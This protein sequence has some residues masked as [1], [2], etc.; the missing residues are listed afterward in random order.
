MKNVLGR[1]I[2]DELLTDGREVFQGQYYRDG[3]VYTKSA[4]TVRANVK[5]SGDKVVENIREA[6][7]KSGLKDGMTISFHHHFRDG[8][9]VVNMVMK[10]IHQLG[11]KDL[12]VCASSLGKAHNYLVPCIEDGTVTGISTSGIRDE[13]GET[14]SAGKLKNPA[15][16]RTHGGRARAIED[17]TVKIDVAFLGAPTSDPYGNASGKGGKSDCGVLSYVDGDAKYADKVV[18]ITDTLVATPNFPASILGVDVDYVVVV[19]SIG[20]PSKIVSGALR[21]TKDTRELMIAENAAK[22]MFHSG[23]FNDGFTFQTGAGGPSLATTVF[24]KKY[25]D[26]KAI[27]CQWAMGGITEPIVNLFKE[28]YIKKIINDQAFDLPAV[29]SVHTDPNHF[30]ISAS[31]YANPFNKGAFVNQLDFVILGAL[32]VD[33]DFNVNVV[34]GTTGILQGAPGGHT[35]TSAGSKVSI[36]VAPLI[37]TRLATVRTKV[38]SVTTPGESIDIVVTDYGVAVNPKRTDLIEAFKNTDI[39]LT[40][41]EELRDLAYQYAGEPEEIEFEDKVVAMIEYRDGTIIDVVKK[42]KNL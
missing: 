31:Q 30:E 2:P 3:Y 1:E 18:I 40:T 12:T 23:F 34:Q 19:D 10:E 4:P 8:D 21:L 35:D 6:I 27:K 7:I 42:P 37:R 24:L 16:I 17:G 38:T 22:C 25:M 11:I 13:I 33:V 26:E 32:E 39:P 5:P 9:F 36:I 20:D 15:F 29:A 28:G 41:I 14:V